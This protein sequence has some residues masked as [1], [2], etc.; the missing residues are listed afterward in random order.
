M[1]VKLE[2]GSWFVRFHVLVEQ[3]SLVKRIDSSLKCKPKSG[4][5]EELHHEKALI[6]KGKLLQLLIIRHMI[7]SIK[8]LF[9]P[10]F[11]PSILCTPPCLPVVINVG[12][13]SLLIYRGAHN[14]DFHHVCEDLILGDIKWCR[15]IQN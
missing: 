11:R 13:H 10:I 5:V 6:N 15:L 2:I 1:P 3:N 14:I 4:K 8:R 7:L 12:Q 9:M